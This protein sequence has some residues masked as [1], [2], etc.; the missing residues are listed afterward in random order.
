M[1]IVAMKTTL[2]TSSEEMLTP[3][4]VIEHVKHG[5]SRGVECGANINIF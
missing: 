1:P 5:G 2:Y 4:F 3:L